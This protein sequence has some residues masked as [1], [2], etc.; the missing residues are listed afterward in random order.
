VSSA[1]PEGGGLVAKIMDGI[2]QSA[3]GITW[4]EIVSADDIRA[5]TPRG[6]ERRR[7]VGLVPLGDGRFVLG[8]RGTRTLTWSREHGLE[9][10][11]DLIDWSGLPRVTMAIGPERTVAVRDYMPVPLLSP[12]ADEYA[13]PRPKR[14]PV[15]R[16]YRPTIANVAAMRPR[17]RLECYGGRKLTFKAWIPFMEYGGVCFFGAPH[18]WMECEDYYLASGPGSSPGFLRY[19]LAP[20]ARLDKGLQ[21]GS[22]GTHVR[23]TGHFDDPAARQCPEP[24]WNGKVPQGWD[25]MTRSDFVNECRRQF[26][27]TE[28]QRL[29]DG[30]E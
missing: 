9:V 29:K 23:V 12:P 7:D 13:E 1:Q 4:Q 25:R 3:D 21:P 2:S 24:G 19:A 17:E 14:E 26:V 6:K 15:C 22:S 16:P 10:A 11:E 20:D 30:T 27:V 18:S 8:G 28:M 5:A